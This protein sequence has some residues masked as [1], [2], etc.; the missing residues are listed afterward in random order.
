ML[1]NFSSQTPSPEKANGTFFN[2]FKRIRKRNCYGVI[3]DQGYYATAAT[4][5]QKVQ[6]CDARMTL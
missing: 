6:E 2:F 5:K 4:T 3:S 1:Y